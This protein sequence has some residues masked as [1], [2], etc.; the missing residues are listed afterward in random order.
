MVAH[1]QF[2]HLGGRG[3]S[4]LVGVSSLLYHE[5]PGDEQ[6][7]R[8]SNKH[9][10]QV[11]FQASLNYTANLGQPVLQSR[12]DDSAVQNS[13][14]L[15]RTQV[16]FLVFTW[17]LTTAYNSSSSHLLPPSDLLRNLACTQ[18][19]YVYIHAGKTLIKRKLKNNQN[20]K[21]EQ[22]EIEGT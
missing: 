16:W 12:K 15:Q 19:M 14:L 21:Q 9:S 7:I 1:F 18:Y 6:T 8:F 20:S 13:L 5:G 3:S 22:R 10:N 11:K 17:Q 2:Q 4:Q